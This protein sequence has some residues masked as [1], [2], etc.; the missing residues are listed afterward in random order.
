MKHYKEALRE[1]Q[2]EY[3]QAV[4]STAGGS[5]TQA[6]AIAGLNRTAFYVTCERA[7]VHLPTRQYNGNAEWRA[8]AS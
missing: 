5:V 1:W 6:A 3:L 8:M 7:G 2:Q 4:L